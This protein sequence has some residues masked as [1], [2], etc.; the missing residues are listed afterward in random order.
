MPKS[1]KNQ[2]IIFNNIHK[3]KYAH[4]NEMQTDDNSDDDFNFNLMQ[5]SK[6]DDTALDEEILVETINFSNEC[7]I[8]AKYKH[9]C[10]CSTENFWKLVIWD[11][12]P[13][14]GLQCEQNCREN[15]IKICNSY[16]EEL[17]GGKLKS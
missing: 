14:I 12:F 17:R 4:D 8:F 9:F 5:D 3:Y 10:L 1:T 6:L 7:R 13:T 15:L 16:Y 2:K 11:F